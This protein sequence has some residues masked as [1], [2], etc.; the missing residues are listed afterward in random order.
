MKPIVSENFSTCAATSRSRPTSAALSSVVAPRS[1]SW[2]TAFW[3]AVRTR[4]V[5]FSIRE[6]GGAVFQLSGF[7]GG[8]AHQRRRLTG[9]VTGALGGRRHFL[10]GRLDLLRR[11]R[12]RLHVLRRLIGR[13]GHGAEGTIDRNHERE[14]RR[15]QL[16]ELA[17][18]LAVHR[19]VGVPDAPEADELARMVERDEQLRTGR[20]AARHHDLISRE[21]VRYDG[22]A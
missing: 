18:R 9:A 19:G 14:L 22:A 4:S 10:A 11:G 12:E 16:Q 2:R 1:V 15:Q 5:V 17:V 7:A 20:F 13:A 8:G 21:A 3:V 6:L